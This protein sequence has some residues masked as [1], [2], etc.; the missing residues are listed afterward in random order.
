MLK[1]FILFKFFLLF[2]IGF[3]LNAQTNVE[4]IKTYKQR[5]QKNSNNADSL[6]Y[7]SKLLLKIEDSTAQYEGY[8]AKAY[9]FRNNMIVDSAL[10]NFQ[11][12]LKLAD[13]KNLKSRAI[14]MSLITA[15][16]GGKNDLALGY[17]EQMFE[18]ANYS[19]D[20]LLLAHAFNQRGI[21][22]KEKGNLELAIE[23]Y[24][25]ASRIYKNIKNP[26]IVN[27]HTNIAIAYDILGQDT[28]ALK[29]FRETYKEA[30]AYKIPRI[31][32]RATNNLANHFKTL[33]QY[34]SSEVYY[35]QL[36]I[37]EDQLNRFY[38]TLLYQ[39]LSELS[40]Y[41]EE[42]D[43][44]RKYLDLVKPLII[45]GTN[46]ERKIQIYSVASKLENAL[47]QY[48]KSLV[49]IDS[50]IL[51]A[52]QF[53][54]PN[55]LYPLYL[56][57]AEIHKTLKQFLPATKCYERYTALR[58]SLQNVQEIQV[59]QE[60]IAKYELESR[61]KEMKTFIE[62]EKRLKSNLFMIGFI[63]II[64][65]LGAIVF[66]WRYKVTKSKHK[67]AEKLVKAN[68]SKLEKL[69]KQLKS[70]NVDKK[71]KLKNNQIINCSD[72]LYVKSDGHYLNF[73]VEDRKIPIV[74]REKLSEILHQLNDCGF[75]RI[76]RSYIINTQKI[77]AV[78]YD[79]I[80]LK[81]KREVPFSRTYRNKLKNQGHPILS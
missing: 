24:T 14:R 41:N 48:D 23:D 77:K 76:H 8:F 50:A 58:D 22:Y 1:Y 33:K 6:F 52:K 46:I 71:I 32:I 4:L 54:L 78:N 31:E 43:K 60:S 57:K 35:N 36:L 21:I 72:L 30:K 61:E 42:F 38:K 34:D 45:N 55:R 15:V 18:L 10:V 67:V 16:N 70:Q 28:I 51:L 39:S 17:A 69:Q 59:I 19:N 65:L 64:L 40:V 37:K 62:S 44:A 53:K 26:G 20:T 80:V 63:S 66:Y 56:R 9:A 3:Q 47:K 13:Q 2:L 11:N 25:K 5:C 74:I 81:Q 49:Q 68:T 27:A 29:W 73:Y 75:L 7:Y 79:N 12:A